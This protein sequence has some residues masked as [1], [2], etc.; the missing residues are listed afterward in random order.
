MAAKGFQ[1]KTI[2]SKQTLGAR[3]KALRQKKHLSLETAEQETK[4]R[5]RYLEAIE[6]DRWHEISL[7]HCKGFIRRYGAYLGLTSEAIEQELAILPLSS[8]QK[9]PFSPHML[10]RSSPWIVTPRTIATGASIVVLL[11][12]IGYVIFQVR[13]FAAPPTLAITKPEAEAVVTTDTI[14]IEGK[15]DPGATITIDNLQ[16]SAASDGTFVS[17]LVLRPGLNQ[18]TVR[19]ENRIKKQTTR[20]ISI[21]YQPNE[22]PTP[23]PT[24]STSP[25]PTPATTPTPSPKPTKKT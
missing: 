9:Q 14:A 15:S 8:Y 7:S 11:L 17:T 2:P 1:Q 22:A 20:V 19:S 12:F 21:L 4:I 6:E 18:V 16:A 5:T 23:S 24:P 13:R 3:L 10:R 25:S